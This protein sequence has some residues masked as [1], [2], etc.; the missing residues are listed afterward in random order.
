MRLLHDS[1]E[2]IITQ[3]IDRYHVEVDLGDN[4]PV[5]VH[6]DELIPIDRAEASYLGGEKETDRPESGSQNPTVLGT[7]MVELSLVVAKREEDQFELVL[8]NPEPIEI[9]YTCYA[10]SPKSFQGLRIGRLDSGE[11]QTLARY[12]RKDL[13]SYKGFYFQVLG[14]RPGKG[15]P[16]APFVR[17]LLWNRSRLQEPVKTIAALDSPG[18]VFNL[19]EDPLVKAVEKIPESEFIR[20]RE[21]EAPVYRPEPEIDL[22]IEALVPRAYQL[23]PSEIISIQQKRIDQALNDSLLEHYAS[24]VLIHGVGEGTLRKMVHETLKKAAH[25]KSFGPAD[26]NRYGNGATKIIFK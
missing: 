4:F 14:F 12:N 10:R 18:W 7:S 3:L 15:H 6:I 23:S 17:E 21:S 19:R 2:G 16:H 1:G 8:I 22:H 24:M 5:D 25:V 26:L 11:Y 20:V 13:D 9:V